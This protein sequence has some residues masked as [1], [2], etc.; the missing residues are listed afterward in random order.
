[1]IDFSGAEAGT[2][3][4]NQFNTMAADALDPYFTR[5]PFI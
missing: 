3:C 1:M 4:D 5:G 2:L